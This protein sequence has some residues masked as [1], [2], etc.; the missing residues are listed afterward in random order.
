MADEEGDEDASEDED[1]EAKPKAKAGAGTKW[2]R[3]SPKG[4][5]SPLRTVGPA[6]ELHFPEPIT[7]FAWHY[8]GDYIA[9]LCPTLGARGVAIHQVRSRVLAADPHVVRLSLMPPDDDE[10]DDDDE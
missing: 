3:V 9:T 4:T 6:V 8:K 7:N 5:A 2:K 1:D 10:Y